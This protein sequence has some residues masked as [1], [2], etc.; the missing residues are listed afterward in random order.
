MWAIAQDS[1]IQSN[2]LLIMPVTGGEIRELARVP[3]PPELAERAP[4]IVTVRWTPDGK[5]LLYNVQ[6][7]AEPAREPELWRVA[8]EG[9][10]PKRLDVSL[11]MQRASLHPDGSR[12]AFWTQE[13]RTEIWLMEGFPWQDSGR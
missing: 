3:R 9:G 8:A 2:M 13:E 5:W 6:W 11:D 1:I 7:P 12:V 10:A 4:E